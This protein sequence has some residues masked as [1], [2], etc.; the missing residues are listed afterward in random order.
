MI[1]LILILAIVALQFVVNWF[2]Y[3][4]RKKTQSSTAVGVQT[5]AKQRPVNRT[6]KKP[7]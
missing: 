2:L 6:S 7:R 3:K 1:T 4:A 5:V